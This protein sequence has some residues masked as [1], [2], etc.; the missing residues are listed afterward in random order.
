MPKI[1]VGQM[2]YS[3]VPERT[4]YTKASRSKSGMFTGR[5]IVPKVRSDKTYVV[6]LKKDFDVNKD[7]KIGSK[8]LRTGQ[9][10]GRTSKLTKPRRVYITRHFRNGKMVKHHLRR[11]R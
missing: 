8:D 6:R 4:K 7:G 5:V 10:I 3:V 2:Y 9:I 11:V 1:T